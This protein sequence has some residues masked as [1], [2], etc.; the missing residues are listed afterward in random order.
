M[1]IDLHTHTIYSDGGLTPLDLVRKAKDIG[2]SALAVADHDS[3]S[4]LSQAFDEARK[5]GIELVPAVEVSAYPNAENEYHIL[6]Y[7]IDWKNSELQG[8][9][10]IFQDAR[11]ERAHKIVEKLNELGYKVTFDEVKAEAKGI[12]VQPHVAA[13][14]IKNP[15]NEE[16]LIKEYGKV[17]STGDFI[18]DHLIQGKDAYI[19]REAFTPEEAINFVHRFGGVAVLAHPCWN[20]A[21]KNPFKADEKIVFDDESLR[22]LVKIGLDGIE[23]YAHRENEKDT[24]DCV[25]HYLKLAGEL[26]LVVTGGSDFHGYGSAGKKLGF[27]DFYLKV[28]DEVLERLKEKKN[29]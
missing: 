4:G 8:S 27:E 11:E 16:K 6:G 18:R 29:G 17:P 24:Q 21:K 13:A 25:D 2:L 15:A 14:V 12:I 23:V 7:F 1:A 28:P 3:V 22:Q 10:K 5:V 9:L 26:D 20:L 19:S